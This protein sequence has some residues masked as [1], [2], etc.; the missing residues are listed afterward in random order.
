MK[1]YEIIFLL[2]GLALIV[3][4]S[5]FSSIVTIDTTV[6]IIYFLLCL[7]IAARYLVK[8]KIFGAEFQFK[9]KIE[10]ARE[11]VDKSREV[12]KEKDKRIKSSLGL[13]DL[14]QAKKMLTSDPVLALA[15]LRIE[16]ENKL[17]DAYGIAYHDK[18]MNLT[19]F[20]IIT[21]LK[22]KGWLYQEQVEALSRIINMCNKAVHGHKISLTDAQNIVNLADDLN[23]T[24][25]VGYFPN[26]K[27]NES[28][29]EQ[30]LLCEWEHCI[31]LM[32]LNNERSNRDCPVFGHECPGGVSQ[33]TKCDKSRLRYQT[34]QAADTH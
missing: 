32:P 28:F 15:S 3:S 8:A 17:R 5:F 4:R 26:F 24:F 2:L 14:S 9:E 34:A 13:F 10:E 27:P 1:F 23:H 22:D 16:I 7:P 33:V 21:R 30:G 25:G 18:D 29:D 6:I 20:N 12:A 11:Y 31:E 19:L